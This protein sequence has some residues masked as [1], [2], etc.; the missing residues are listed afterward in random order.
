[1]KNKFSFSRVT[2]SSLKKNI[3]VPRFEPPTFGSTGGAVQLVTP[4]PAK[5]KVAGSNVARRQKLMNFQRISAL[6]PVT[7]SALS[8]KKGH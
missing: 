7:K 6:Y 3:P 4:P 1:M 8:V 5:P 2:I